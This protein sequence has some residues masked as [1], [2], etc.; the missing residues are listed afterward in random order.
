VLNCVEYS[1][2]TFKILKYLL[3]ADLSIIIKNKQKTLKTKRKQW[4]DLKA[5][6]CSNH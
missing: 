1:L 2:V 6:N 3:F 4:K 5:K